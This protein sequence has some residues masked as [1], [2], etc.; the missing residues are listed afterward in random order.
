MSQISPMYI[1]HLPMTKKYYVA[2]VRALTTIIR[3]FVLF[4]FAFTRHG[5]QGSELSKTLAV[6][7]EVMVVT[8]ELR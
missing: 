3:S 1:V 6:S 8:N 7:F 5:R 4:A 2:G